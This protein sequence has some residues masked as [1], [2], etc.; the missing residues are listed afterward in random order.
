MEQLLAHL[1]GD[2]ILQTSHMAEHKI[3]HMGVAAY[4]AF[5]YSLPFLLITQSP[6]ALAVIFG[7]HT[8]IDRYRLAAYVA[9]F[10]NMAGDVKHWEEYITYTGYKEETPNWLAVW[11][12]IVTDNT[13]HLLVNF[14]AIKYL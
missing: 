3:K 2:Y 13:I 12:V 7:T 4:H 8:I 10:K 14:F 9:R 11:L 6:A 5:I 1:V